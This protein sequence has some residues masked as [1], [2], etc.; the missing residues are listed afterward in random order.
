MLITNM[1]SFFCDKRFINFILHVF[2]YLYGR[3]TGIYANVEIS[4]ATK[5]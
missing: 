1:L 4:F 3:T 2:Q 5:G